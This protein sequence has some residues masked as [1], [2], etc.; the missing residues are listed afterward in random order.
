M[1]ERKLSDEEIVKA[2]DCGCL[3]V[4]C[5]EHCEKCVLYDIESCDIVPDAIVDLIHRLQDENERM[6]KD[7]VENCKNCSA[8]KVTKDVVGQEIYT[9]MTRNV[10]RYLRERFDVEV[11]NE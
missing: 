6:K 4:V 7:L 1:E 3:A 5:G 9:V 8:I 11:E 10:K 2:L